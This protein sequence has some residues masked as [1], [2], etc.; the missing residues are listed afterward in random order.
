M[1]GSGSEGGQ[2]LALCGGVGGAKLAL[3]LSRVLPEGALLICGNTGDD[4][5]HLGLYVAPD[6]DTVLYTL[7]G[8][9]NPETG[10]G[11]RDESWHFMAA[12]ADLGGET[13]FRLGDRDLAVHV[14]R[15]R[16]LRAGERLGAITADLARRLGV[17]ALILPMSNDPVR[18]LVETD[19]GTLAFQHYFVRLR[20]EPVVKRIR[21]EGAERARPHPDVLAAIRSPATRAIVLCP[22]NPYLSIDPIL[23][24][25]GLRAAL[26]AAPAPVVAVSPLIAGAAVK[27]PTAKI[28]RELG[29]PQEPAQIARH[30]ADLLDGLVVD[31]ADRAAAAGLSV[32]VAVTAT[33]MRSL[34][35]RE[36]LARDVLAFAERLAR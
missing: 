29:V 21:F 7:A 5:E 15:T 1:S 20:A 22:S 36:R 17:A 32:P 28:M 13:W 31:G 3:G 18:T 34:E 23:A 25:P 27:G 9:A 14:E 8:L 33:L 11:R 6:L 24:V 35:D 16:R 26:A 4:F 19:R 12:L 30:Y 2:V 10:W